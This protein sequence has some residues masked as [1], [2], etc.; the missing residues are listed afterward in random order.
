MDVTLSPADQELAAKVSQKM[1]KGA[2]KQ[3]PE[4]LAQAAYLVIQLLCLVHDKNAPT[5]SKK[6]K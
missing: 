6:E 1:L 5:L 3:R 2:G 4:I